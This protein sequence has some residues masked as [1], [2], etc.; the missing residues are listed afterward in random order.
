MLHP[1]FGGFRQGRYSVIVGPFSHK[2]D[3]VHTHHY[4]SSYRSLQSCEPSLYAFCVPS[5]PHHNLP[6]CPHP[7]LP[8]HF[9]NLATRT[10]PISPPAAAAAAPA[11]ATG[12]HGCAAGWR[13]AAPPLAGAG[14]GTCGRL[15]ARGPLPHQR[16]ERPAVGCVGSACVYVQ[17]R[18]RGARVCM[19]MCVCVT[20]CHSPLL[21]PHPAW[22]TLRLGTSHFLMAMMA[23]T[24]PHPRPRPRPR[25]ARPQALGPVPAPQP[26]AGR[27]AVG[28][29][30][31]RPP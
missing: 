31:G 24:S 27:G 5:A 14:A 21:A 17:T 16:M 19:C 13:A 22:H 1:W 6:G 29:R 26:A 25:P 11:P 3:T 18:D 15:L 23:T 28:R 4:G 2:T 30:R 8:A 7:H 10:R 12:L 9:L 20:M